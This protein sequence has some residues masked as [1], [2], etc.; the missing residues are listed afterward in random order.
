MAPSSAA[1]C[2]LG[3]RFPWWSFRRQ[4]RPLHMQAATIH[5]QQ[6]E[7]QL[8]ILSFRWD[9]RCAGH[10][11]RGTRE[12]RHQ[13]VKMIHRKYL[14]QGVVTTAAC[15]PQ[16]NVEAQ[17]KLS[18]RSRRI[19]AQVFSRVPTLK[20]RDVL[21]IKWMGTSTGRQGLPPC[22][23]MSTVI[24]LSTSST[25]RMLKQCDSSSETQQGEWLRR[26]A[27]QRIWSLI[28]VV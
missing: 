12:L 5:M 24:S 7:Y 23:W 18:T 4:L 10:T 6:S 1:P 21:V 19:A 13:E 15:L 16:P 9:G 28:M 26:C 27:H 25:P 17:S 11:Y 8:P 2:R 22:P 20:R 14:A 3:C